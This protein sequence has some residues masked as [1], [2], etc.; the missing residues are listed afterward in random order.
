MARRLF[1]KESS[2]VDSVPEGFITI[3]ND[4]GQ[5]KTGD[6][7]GSKP[8]SATGEKFIT[9]GD[10]YQGELA[11]LNTDGTVSVPGNVE[12]DDNRA[13]NI[14]GIFLS[15]ASDS[16]TVS[17]ITKGIISL[18][19]FDF[20]PRTIYY[21]TTDGKLTTSIT[22]YIFGKSLSSNNIMI[23]IS[24]MQSILNRYGVTPTF[25]KLV[26]SIETNG[27]ITLSWSSEDQIYSFDIPEIGTSE[28]FEEPLSSPATI[29]IS[30]VV[31]NYELQ[32]GSYQVGKITNADRKQVEFKFQLIGG[33]DTAI[34]AR[35]TGLGGLYSNDGL[36]VDISNFENVFIDILLYSNG[37]DRTWKF[38]P[39]NILPLRKL[40]GVDG[41]KK[42][43]S[44]LYVLVNIK[45][46][47][48][49]IY[50]SGIW[51][52]NSST[53]NALAITLYVTSPFKSNTVF[54]LYK[55]D[56]SPVLIYEIECSKLG[57]E[58]EPTV[59]TETDLKI[60]LSTKDTYT[61][62]LNVDG[63]VKPKGGLKP[64]IEN[65]KGTDYLQFGTVE[66][67]NDEIEPPSV[68]AEYNGPSTNYDSDTGLGVFVDN[69]EKDSL[70][71]LHII[72]LSDN[73]F[74]IGEFNENVSFITDRRDIVISGTKY[75]LYYDSVSYTWGEYTP[76]P[77]IESGVELFEFTAAVELAPDETQQVVN[78][79][80]SPITLS[81]F[82]ELDIAGYNLT[83]AGLVTIS[84]S[85]PDR[86]EVRNMG[87]ANNPTEWSS[88][89]SISVWW[90]LNYTEIRGG[91][92]FEI[93]MKPGWTISSNEV[94]D[95]APVEGQS[96][97]AYSGEVY[98]NSNEVSITIPLE[99][100]IYEKSGK[101]R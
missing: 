83:D 9:K 28:D 56:K 20:E 25:D 66:I 81:N 90:L 32:V 5:I 37:E 96:Y 87:V 26:T 54:E 60:G 15:D 51:D 95:V 38:G 8:I 72:L 82:N 61:W 6:S 52:S 17:I 40:F 80:V 36:F 69:K 47:E 86:I 99:V 97:W 58:K 34:S 68:V 11:Y 59:I 43:E 42:D 44:G 67:A 50:Q 4:G 73:T 91:L 64:S 93:R 85:D 48:L 39:Q 65:I 71:T 35:Y 101:L 13:D 46:T 7:T 70:D 45:E 1:I 63:E 2:S 29:D 12:G 55:G 92:D 79:T 84:V 77:I 62:A 23:D 75:S 94:T 24:F 76:P 88:E 74:E 53:V 14:I 19:T 3:S 10:V 16:D 27:I 22:P 78:N 89:T 21:I 41:V 30:D 57:T 18:D 33:S 31:E 100:S 49:K 98:I